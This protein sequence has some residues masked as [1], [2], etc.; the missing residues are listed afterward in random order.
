VIYVFDLLDYRGRDLKR[1][2][3]A[4]RRPALEAIAPELPR[5][6]SG[7]PICC[8]RTRQW[9]QLVATLDEHGLEGIVVKRKD[10]TYLVARWNIRKRLNATISAATAGSES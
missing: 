5:S 1:L 6:M 2:P 9:D 4:V 3:L 8:P 10:S 7:S